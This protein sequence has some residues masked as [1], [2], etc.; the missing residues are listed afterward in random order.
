MTTLAFVFSNR[1]RAAAALVKFPIYARE[2][3]VAFDSRRE[4]SSSYGRGAVCFGYGDLRMNFGGDKQQIEWNFRLAVPFEGIHVD[5]L[6]D[7][8]HWPTYYKRA[9]E[10][11]L[12]DVGSS[13]PAEDVEV[14]QLL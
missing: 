7:N 3:H 13:F 4:N 9:Y 2:A 6:P 5:Y 1:G 8:G 12:F 14:F 10:R 11:R